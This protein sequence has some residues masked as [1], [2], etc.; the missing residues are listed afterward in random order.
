MVTDKQDLSQ[1]IGAAVPRRHSNDLLVIMIFVLDELL[2]L[3]FPT[4]QSQ[5]E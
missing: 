5:P 3:R 1:R 4:P 2:P